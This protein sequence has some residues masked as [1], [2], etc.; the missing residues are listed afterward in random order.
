ME[1]DIQGGMW[2]WGGMWR[3]EVGWY[4]EGGGGY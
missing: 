2:R 3:V 4:V 1:V